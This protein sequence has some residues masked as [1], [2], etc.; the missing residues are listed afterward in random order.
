MKDARLPRE[1]KPLSHMPVVTNLILNKIE[2]PDISYED[3]LLRNQS[4]KQ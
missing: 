4:I 2:V 3:S 1:L